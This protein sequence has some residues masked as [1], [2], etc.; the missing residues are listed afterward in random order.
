MSE[1]LWV[2]HLDFSDFPVVPFHFYGLA[3]ASAEAADTAVFPSRGQG[4]KGDD[5]ALLIA[6]QQHLAETRAAAEVA[7]NLEGA[8][9]V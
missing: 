7:V 6:L 5:A 9:G 4:R 8:V 3:A 1:V 2:Y